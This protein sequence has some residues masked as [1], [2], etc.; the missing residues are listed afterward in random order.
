MGRMAD[1]V[2][3]VAVG[4]MSRTFLPS[5]IFGMVFFCGSVGVWNP[6][7]STSLRM[8]LTK[9]LKMFSCSACKNA[10]RLQTQRD[11]EEWFSKSV[12]VFSAPK[13][14]RFSA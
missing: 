6:R 2:L 7:C 8:G 14:K 4:E 12:L 10:R 3:P 11:S 5:R 9:R 13:L 1:S